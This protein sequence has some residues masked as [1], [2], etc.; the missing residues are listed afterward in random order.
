[1]FD[2]LIHSPVRHFARTTPD[3]AAFS[4]SGRAMT[5]A[6][7]EAAS[8]R[9]AHALRDDGVGRQD[10][11]GI[12]MRKALELGPA[13]YGTLKAG[14]A[15]VPLDPAM[16]VERLA[17]ILRDCGIRHV[18]TSEGQRA[19]LEALAAPCTGSTAG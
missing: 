14:G 12:F 1:M 4:C 19:P 5:W 15:F 11:V 7:L 13:I 2:F 3:R 18:V 9:L 6:E 17:F 16:P 10:R 8:N